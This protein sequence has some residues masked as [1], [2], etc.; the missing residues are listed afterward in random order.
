MFLACK[1]APERSCFKGNG[2][3]SEVTHSIE[4]VNVFELGKGI[5]YL[6]YQDSSN[7]IIVRGGEN[8]IHKIELTQTDSVLTIR[9]KNK[10]NF[11]RK[12]DSEDNSDKI[13][14]EIHYPAYHYIIGEPTDSILFM[15]TITGEHLDITVSNG[16]ASM[17]LNVN[18]NSLYILFHDGA[19]DFKVRGNVAWK[20]DLIV[21]TNSW[22]N[23]EGLNCPNYFLHNRST[24]DL[25]VNLSNAGASVFL[26]GTGNIYYTGAYTSVTI[27]KQGDG[28]FLPK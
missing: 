22:G 5:K 9:N 28:E 6:F 23:A 3:L 14:V 26:H 12:K 15:D 20:S 10:C 8:L 13:V 16:A 1:K 19:G 7:Q 27:D 17:D 4:N 24:G 11:L 18:L 21:K 25:H 2:T